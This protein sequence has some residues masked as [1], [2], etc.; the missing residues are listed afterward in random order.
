MDYKTACEFAIA[1]ALPTGE[2]PD[3]FLL[4]LNAGEPPIPGQVTSLLLALRIIFEQSH[5]ETELDRHLVCALH[6]L[7]TE[8]RQAFIRHRELGV[9]WPPLLDRDLSQMAIAVRQIFTGETTRAL[10]GNRS[11]GLPSH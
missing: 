3:A 2:N 9:I 4:R 8:S 11:L 10:P 7:V 1:Q 6:V 5:G